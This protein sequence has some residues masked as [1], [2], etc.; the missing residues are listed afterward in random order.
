[1]NKESIEYVQSFMARIGL[2]VWAPNLKE[3]PASLLNAECRI[4]AIQTFRD[5]AIIFYGQMNLNLWY[6]D[7]INFLNATYN[8]FVHHVAAKRHAKSIIGVQQHAIQAESVIHSN[9][10]A[11]SF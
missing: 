9:R 7:D 8:Y 3:S 1:M 4:S 10:E 11:V 2:R 6:L 5:L